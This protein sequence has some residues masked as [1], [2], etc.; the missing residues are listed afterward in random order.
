VL[1]ARSVLLAAEGIANR[2]ATLFTAFDVATGTVTGRVYARH[3]HQEFLA[4]LKV[5][6]QR[7]PDIEI[8]LVLDNYRTHKHPVVK[9]WL[10]TTRASSSI[11]PRPARVG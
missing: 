9:Q 5:I 7:Y 4:F 10:A 11:S 6:A 3:R 2:R 8:H 1:R